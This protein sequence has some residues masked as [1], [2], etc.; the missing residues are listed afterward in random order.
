MAKRGSEDLKRLSVM[1]AVLVRALS[2]P[3]LCFYFI[4]VFYSPI[5]RRH[6]K[7]RCM[8][9]KSR[10]LHSNVLNKSVRRQRTVVQGVKLAVDDYDSQ[11]HQTCVA[12]V[13]LKYHSS[14]NA[15]SDLH[16]QT[17]NQRLK[18]KDKHKFSKHNSLHTS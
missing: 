3:L 10:W 2:S 4:F 9:S 8:T 5:K 12:T 6:I 17:S 15:R 11:L 1:Q 18:D 16:P 13:F 14:S 7:K